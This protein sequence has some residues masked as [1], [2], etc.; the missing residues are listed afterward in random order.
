MKERPYA[1]CLKTL[2]NDLRL[3]TLSELQKK[4]ASVLELCKALGEE[5]STVSHSLQ[6]LRTCN[7]VDVK[8]VGK[9]RIYSIK[10]QVREGLRSQKDNHHL[11]DF[12]DSHIEHCCNNECNKLRRGSSLGE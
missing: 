5:Q 11:F 3:Q 7:Y 4:P 12:L 9:Q 1:L 2:A 6:Q 10:P 8:T